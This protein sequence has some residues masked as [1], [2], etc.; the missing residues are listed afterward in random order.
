MACTHVDNCPL[1]PL[2]SD[3]LPDWIADYCEGE[4]N[5]TNCARY[6]LGLSGQTVPITLLPNGRYA[7]SLATRTVSEAAELRP[8][9]YPPMV[10]RAA[11]RHERS[12]PGP[13]VLGLLNSP[14]SPEPTQPTQ[15]THRTRPEAGRTL[16]RWWTRVVRWL[17]API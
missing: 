10:A 14:G 12:E 16:G 3:S 15:P 11:R 1:F 5:G 13:T 4:R 9:V 2:L 6:Q 17:L 7:H 8:A